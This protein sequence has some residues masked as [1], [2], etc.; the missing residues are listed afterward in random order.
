MT[1][2]FMMQAPEKQKRDNDDLAC[3]NYILQDRLKVL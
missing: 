2:N 3:Q 1:D